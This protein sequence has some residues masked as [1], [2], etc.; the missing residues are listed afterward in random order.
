MSLSR[1]WVVLVVL[2]L[3]A[4][5]VQAANWYVATNGNDAANGTSWI[6][7]KSTIQAAVD[8]SSDADTVW[9][10]NGVY[11]TGGRVVHGSMTNRVAIVKSITVRS[12]NGPGATIIRGAWDP[13]R[14]NGNAA[15]RCV[16]VGANAVLSGFTL[17]NGATRAMGV[18]GMYTQECGG[19]AW[20][21]A[22]GT[23]SNCTLTGNSASSGGGGAIYGTLNHCTLSGNSGS[24]RGGGA[25]YGTL[26]HCTLSGNSA[27]EGGGSHS[28]TLNNCTLSGNSAG[29]AGGSF[30]GVLNNC[31]V[32]FN[33]ARSNPNHY[34]SAFS[35]SCT[36][37]LPGGVGN[38]ANDPL[39]ASASHLA[40]GSPC[41]GAGISA[42]AS[43]TDIDGQA[44][45]NP[46]SMGCAEGG[47]D[48]NTGALSVS[49]WAAYTN[50]TAGFVVQ[51]RM[52]ISGRP[53]SSAWLWG[54]GSGS[55]N[56]PYAAHAFAS[57]GVYAVILKADNES[58]PLGVAATV[59]V[60]V[61]EQT[62]HYVDIGNSTPAPPYTTWA[63]AA[64]NI[65]I[66]INAVYQ[67]GAL[68]LVT[69]GVYATGG[70]A[71]FG[72]MTNR[73]AIDKPITVRS[74]NGPDATIIRGAW[75]SVTPGE[76]AAVRCA[77]VGTNATLA[78]FTLTNGATVASGDMFDQGG[79]GAY[80]AF[81]GILSNCTLVGNSAY[82]GGG[83]DH[84][85]LS[86]C[87]LSGNSASGGNGGGAFYGALDHCTLSG[88]STS[89]YGGGSYRGGLSHCVL[90]GNSAAK[91]GGG[92]F[93][94]T[95]NNCTLSGNSAAVGG[96][97]Y[98]GTLVNCTLSG[99]SASESGG[100]ASGGVLNNC[101][102]YFNT[103]ASGAN[104]SNTV[105]YYGCT[106]PVPGGPGN[107]T[108]EPQFVDAAAGNYRLRAGSPCMD[109]GHNAYVRVTED[110]DGNPRIANGTV[111][112]GAYEYQG[113]EQSPVGYWAWASSITNGMTNYND[114]AAGDGF[115]NLLKYATGSS[116]T[117]SDGLAEL[118]CTQ[119][120]GLPVLIF[121]RNTNAIDV[122]MIVQGAF[123]LSNKVS[124]RGL[125]TNINGSWG[126]ANNVVESGAGNPVTCEVQDVVPLL[127]NRFLRLKVTLP[128]LPAPEGMVLIPGG[129]N[130]GTN[131]LATNEVP[132]PYILFPETYS[133]TVE[134]FY[135]DKYEVT[136]AL[137][138]EVYTWAITNGYSFDNVGSGKATNHPVHTVN[139]HDTV[140]WC[141]ARSQ[142]EG[143]PAVYT[144]AGA[145]YKTDQA[146]DNDV[147]QTSAAG[148]RLPTAVE[149]E[150]A[151]RGGAASQRF[152]WDDSDEIQHARANYYSLD[153]FS[154]DTS[155]TRKNHPTY[156]KDGAPYTSPAGSFAA[157]GYGLYDM[158][159]NVFEWCFDW[160]PAFVGSLR[161]L[162]GGAWGNSADYCRVGARYADGSPSAYRDYGFRAVLPLGQQ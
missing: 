18:G 129:T 11:A 77:Y 36:T 147:V 17:T 25:I 71:V 63:T 29:D 20:C 34:V 51:F 57:N 47:G 2:C 159:G 153:G 134:P 76:T 75:P 96:G 14:T 87:T 130:A 45:L 5:H 52:D 106:V 162:R 59:T 81:S 53:A 7:A 33:E 98:D 28:S 103:A 105:F 72:S 19:G 27:N 39:L 101:I 26:N 69:N 95:L 157:N 65:Q 126:G 55:S 83:A 118:N 132:D 37:P 15:V 68:V 93:Q 44:W 124:W 94:G 49:A 143:R 43:G 90:S 40:A 116:P 23:L 67:A 88:N 32:Y 42:Y 160:H 4:W 152:P 111:D 24:S 125:A 107:I 121:N 78:G 145:V 91:N 84:S 117:Q 158:A 114:C 6:A 128:A 70:R 149:W 82:W 138:D 122:T 73:V 41:I 66:A 146:Y 64:T 144:V 110:L 148:Y 102:A 123:A 38:I 141:N 8:A 154:Y 46:P 99:N 12:V 104:H 9:V 112:I 22:S 133:L 150:Y 89:G 139:W 151:A 155:L 92:I 30:Y 50:V 1:P 108:D 127:T 142:K 16:Y 79:G 35:Y 21:E 10:S 80:C 100:G 62:V 61:A 120:N 86:H 97:V 56:Q 109:R 85:T 156:A 140:K 54:D 135:M 131:P 119:S 161:V 113:P 3:T 136:K 13:V 115:P 60:Q 74:V 137:W 48:S 31:I 58:H